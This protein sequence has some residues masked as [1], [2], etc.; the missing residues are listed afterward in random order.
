MTRAD[1]ADDDFVAVLAD[2]VR[3]R[4][5]LRAGDV[6]A[7]ESLSRGADGRPVSGDGPGLVDGGVA[8]HRRG[9]RLDGT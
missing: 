2:I 7:A 5:L 9:G 1:E 3:A 6:A 8:A 4:V